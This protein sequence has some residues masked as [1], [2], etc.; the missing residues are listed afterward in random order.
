MSEGV[1]SI[2][3]MSFPG[4]AME[5]KEKT[6]LQHSRVIMIGSVTVDLATLATMLHF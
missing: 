5:P 3:I 2:N 1:V 4:F 6:L